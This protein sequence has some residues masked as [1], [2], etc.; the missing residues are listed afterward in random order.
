MHGQHPFGLQPGL[1]EHVPASS[2]EGLQIT[3]FLHAPSV[4]A[5]RFAITG[6]IPNL[7]RSFV[8]P[9]FLSSLLGIVSAV[10]LIQLFE[11]ALLSIGASTLSVFRP[12]L[13]KKEQMM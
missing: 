4:P 12:P 6:F 7:K 9:T 3:F 1:V 13:G 2:R 8:G 11:T 10:Q 5:R